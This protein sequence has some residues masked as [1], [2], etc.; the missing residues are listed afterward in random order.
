MLTRDELDDMILEDN[1][2]LSRS[3]RKNQRKKVDPLANTL[4]RKMQVK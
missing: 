1:K 4:E 2:E 3:P